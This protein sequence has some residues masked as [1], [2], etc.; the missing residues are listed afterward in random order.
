MQKDKR[1]VEKYL[2]EPEK[3][4]ISKKPLVGD[5]RNHL[6]YGRER[7]DIQELLKNDRSLIVSTHPLKQTV[8]SATIAC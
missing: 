3:L 2:W 5:G 7:T 8:M 1:E 4:I 6:L